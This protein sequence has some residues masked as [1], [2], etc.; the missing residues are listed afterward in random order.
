M[1]GMPTRDGLTS[2]ARN[3]VHS[4]ALPARLPD[5]TWGGP[6]NGSRCP[7]CGEALES[8]GM[9]FE[10]EFAGPSGGVPEYRQMHV[11]CFKAWELEIGSSQ[12]GM[13]PAADTP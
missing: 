12:P 5:H 6:G 13:A 11:I 2:R 1:G 8:Q 4:Q 3:A 7:I 10:L 9:V